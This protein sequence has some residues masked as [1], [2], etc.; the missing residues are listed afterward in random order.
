MLP[1]DQKVTSENEGETFRKR[2][3]YVQ[4]C[5]QAAWKRFQHEYLVALRERHNLNHKGKN[6]SIQIGDVVIIKGQSKNRGNWKLAIVEKLHRGKDNVVRVVGLRTAKNY[7]ERPIQLLCPMELH[8]NTIRKTSETKLNPNVE[9]FRPSRPK[10]TAAAVAKL[11][12][13][14][15]QD[16]DDDI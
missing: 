9:E 5:K 14:D 8:C 3:K 2:Q 7:L 16:V 10:R 6:A 1:P 4:K 11:R 12:I 15:M 13:G